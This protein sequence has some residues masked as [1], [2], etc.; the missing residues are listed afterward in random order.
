MPILQIFTVILVAFFKCTQI[1]LGALPNA[2]TL[3]SLI[4]PMNT[5]PSALTGAKP[6]Q[7]HCLDQTVLAFHL[8]TSNHI[9]CQ[10]HS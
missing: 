6:L 3:D 5:Q 2:E 10:T 1:Y 8:G 9:G 7:V 4:T